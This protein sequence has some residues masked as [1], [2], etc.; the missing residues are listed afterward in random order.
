[1]VV[2]LCDGP[3]WWKICECDRFERIVG[4]IV[5]SAE[6]HVASPVQGQR[7]IPASGN[8]HYVAQ[9]CNL[10]RDAILV[11]RQACPQR[12][13]IIPAPAPSRAV[14]PYSQRVV[15]SSGYGNY[16]RQVHHRGREAKGIR[17]GAMVV[18]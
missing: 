15:C 14:S 13:I 11:A 3:D 6:E 8:G 17:A 16:I 4:V 18:S 12:P 1:M 10:Y 2:A 9:A 7:C 5:E